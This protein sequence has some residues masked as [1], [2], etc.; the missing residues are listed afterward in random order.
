MASMVFEVIGQLRQTNLCEMFL[1][2][3]NVGFL[4]TD[5]PVAVD[6]DTAITCLI[7]IL[8][9]AYGQASV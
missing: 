5:K 7:L 9:S 3:K 2:Y 1:W 8:P 4:V 6:Q